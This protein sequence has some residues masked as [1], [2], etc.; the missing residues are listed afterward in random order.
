MGGMRQLVFVA[1]GLI[2][3]LIL[4]LSQPGTNLPRPS[5]VVSGVIWAE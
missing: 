2:L 1:S 5:L 3:I 4:P